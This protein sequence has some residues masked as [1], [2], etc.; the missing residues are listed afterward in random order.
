MTTDEAAETTQCSLATSNVISSFDISPIPNNEKKTGTRG[1]KSAS[2]GWLIGYGIKAICLIS[3]LGL[4]VEC[5]P[6]ESF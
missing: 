2:Q 1:R 5:S 3:Y 6:G 4:R